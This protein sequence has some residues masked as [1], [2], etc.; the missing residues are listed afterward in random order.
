MKNKMIE[1]MARAIY[2]LA[3]SE[4]AHWPPHNHV[5]HKR[6]TEKATAAYAS[7]EAMGC[8]V[9]K[10]PREFICESC[11]LRIEEGV[12]PECNF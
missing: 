7:I 8:S 3:W 9:V 11:H 1:A 10:T 6:F 4:T 5:T 2:K 12:K